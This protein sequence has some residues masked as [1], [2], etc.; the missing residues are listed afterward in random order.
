VLSRSPPTGQVLE[1]TSVSN[2]VV[3][4]QYLGEWASLA[5][6]A[7][8]LIAV[9]VSVW[10]ST[11][12]LR[13]AINQFEKRRVDARTDKLR[14]EIIDLITALSERPS[15]S[16]AIINRI[17]ALANKIDLAH[18]SASK[19]WLTIETKAVVS[20]GLSGTYRRIYGHA[21][22]IMMLTDDEAV[23]DPVRRI[24]KAADEELEAFEAAIS[25]SESVVD[26]DRRLVEQL[27][28]TIQTAM[29]EL[30][31]YGLQNLRVAD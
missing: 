17:A 13:R 11:K 1:S 31:E 27:R 10:F 12:T 3:G 30:V 19:D 14:S 28:D 20:E 15:P 26:D 16:D 18:P 2:A 4:W 7:V 6:V 9:V 21:I 22:G 5:A 23:A 25:V 8:A 24:T 29:L